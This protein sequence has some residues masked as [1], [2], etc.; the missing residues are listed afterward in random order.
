MTIDPKTFRLVAGGLA[1]ALILDIVFIGALAL[2]AGITGH[3][4]PIPGMLDDLPKSLIPGLLGLLI[5]ARSEEPVDV[6][7]T[8]PTAQPVPTADVPA[9]ARRRGNARGHLDLGAV[10]TVALIVLVVVVIL[11]LAPKV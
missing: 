11:V 5:N 3:D 10:L 2:V 1:L 7:V 9:K 4:I 8:N 6:K